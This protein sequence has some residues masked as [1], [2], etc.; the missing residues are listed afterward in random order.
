MRSVVLGF[1]IVSA[2]MISAR[3]QS[4]AGV[5]IGEFIDPLFENLRKAKLLP[6]LDSFTSDSARA[7]F[8]VLILMWLIF[9]V[10]INFGDFP[11]AIFS[12]FITSLLYNSIPTLFSID[13]VTGLFKYIFS[14]LFIFVWTDYIMKYVWALS[15]PTKLFLETSIT[16]IAVMFM[17]FGNVF[18]II[19]GWIGLVI[20]WIGFIAF[21]AFLTV[22]RIFN[23][24]FSLMNIKAAK[25]V[26]KTGKEDVVRA[27]KEAETAQ[28]AAER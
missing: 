4:L 25:D 10:A 16:M 14:A 7:F 22:M 20:S 8:I 21:L 13:P 6:S 23:T 2:F 5:D 1:L 3:A 28:K 27:G 15:R 9:S 12:F 19:Q 18:E 24:Y 11:S 26:R 17:E